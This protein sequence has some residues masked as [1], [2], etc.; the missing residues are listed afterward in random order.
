MKVGLF[1]IKNIKRLVN[2]KFQLPQEAKIYPIFYIL[3]LEKASDGELLA[4]GFSYKPEE[5]NVYK[6]ERILNQK[7]N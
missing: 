3:L 6:I 5:N 1:L 7:E 4:T 2:Y